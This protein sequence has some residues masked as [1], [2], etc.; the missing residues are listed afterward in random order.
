MPMFHDDTSETLRNHAFD[1]EALFEALLNAE[2]KITALQRS[3]A[4][5]MAGQRSAI[6]ERDAALAEVETLKT[7]NADLLSNAT[8]LTEPASS[9]VPK[10]CSIVIEIHCDDDVLLHWEEPEPAAD[11]FKG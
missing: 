3:V 6:R 11:K 9:D 7:E 2:D 1:I 8:T 4:T 10:R 5:A